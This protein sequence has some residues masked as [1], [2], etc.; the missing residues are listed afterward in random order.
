M[1]NYNKVQ[2]SDGT[3]LIDLTN[4][5]ITPNDILYGVSAHDAS[6]S[7]IQGTLF[8]DKTQTEFLFYDISDSNEIAVTDD[9]LVAL[10]VAYQF[11][12]DRYFKTIIKE[13]SD[14]IVVLEDKIRA[15]E[16]Q[17]NWLDNNAIVDSFGGAVFDSNN[18]IINI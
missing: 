4:D 12:N 13:K 14:T 17:L 7:I 2:L 16:E 1:P 10:S 15:L 6:G 5:T 3:V 8:Q 11:T 9:K 18:A